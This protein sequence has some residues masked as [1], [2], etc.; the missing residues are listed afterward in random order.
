MNKGPCCCSLNTRLELSSSSEVLLN[1]F[2]IPIEVR[3]LSSLM[4]PK[5][6]KTQRS[7]FVF[8]S[9]PLTQ[10]SELMLKQQFPGLG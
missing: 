7:A 3:G 9:S 2:T 6:G 5:E 1:T 4:G 8:M 10:R